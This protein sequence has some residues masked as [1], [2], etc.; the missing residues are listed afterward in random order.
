MEL[1]RTKEDIQQ[2]GDRIESKATQLATLQE[3]ILRKKQGGRKNRLSL[4]KVKK[5][6]TQKNSKGDKEVKSCNP[7]SLI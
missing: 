1:E 4:V 3:A 5:V 2:M 6:E 7:C